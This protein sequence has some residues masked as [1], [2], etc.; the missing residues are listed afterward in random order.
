MLSCFL[1]NCAFE[2]EAH[3]L[4]LSSGAVNFLPYIMLPLCGP[5]EFDLEESDKFPDEIQL[6]PP[7]KK[8]EEDSSTRLMLV[9]TLILLCATRG[10]RDELRKRGVYEVV[11]VMHR[12]EGDEQVSIAIERLVN[13]IMADEIPE[14][15]IS[16][17]VG[18][19][20]AT[21][22]KQE[23]AKE[24]Q[25]DEDEDEDEMVQEV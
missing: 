5:E 3:P 1:R 25:A 2:Q 22:G 17:I 9:E 18:T 23:N 24:K 16:E 21:T 8:R 12:V 11:R 6:L 13:L 19:A 14:K 4:L 7:D 15:K 20:A 10:G